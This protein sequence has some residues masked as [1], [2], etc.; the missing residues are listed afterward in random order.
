M[1][2]KGKLKYSDRIGFL[3]LGKLFYV[4]KNS[5]RD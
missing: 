4:L 3:S 2:A 1:K 5:F